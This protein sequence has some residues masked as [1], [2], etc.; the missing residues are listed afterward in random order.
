MSDQVLHV[1]VFT[2]INVALGVLAF[3]LAPLIFVAGK[4]RAGSM[5][6][7]QWGVV[8]AAV[9]ALQ[10]L[11]LVAQKRCSSEALPFWRGLLAVGASMRTRWLYTDIFIALLAIPFTLFAACLFLASR[12]PAN[13]FHRLVYRFYEH[14]MYQ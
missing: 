11:L 5:G 10:L 9:I 7:E 8:I 6:I 1:S 2:R 3:S 12:N 13:R 4:I 14:R